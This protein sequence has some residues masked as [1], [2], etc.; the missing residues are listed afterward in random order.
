VSIIVLGRTGA[1][2]VLSGSVSAAVARHTERPVLIVHAA[3]PAD[4]ERPA[5]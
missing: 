1:G 3:A 2:L 5:A 4:A